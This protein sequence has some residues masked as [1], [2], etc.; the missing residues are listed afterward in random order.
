M[1]IRRTPRGFEK[2]EFLDYYNEEAEL[3]QSSVAL[4]EQPG[5]GAIWLGQPGHRMHL[6]YSQVQELMKHL[7]AWIDT[8]SFEIPHETAS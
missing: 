5:W 2:I 6:E 3:Q 7:Q 1:E 8:G 4:T